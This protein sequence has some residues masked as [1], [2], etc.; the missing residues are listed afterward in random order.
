MSGG[1]SPFFSCSFL[2]P[3]STYLFYPLALRTLEELLLSPIGR[4]LRY[5][6]LLSSM[7]AVTP[8]P[9]KEHAELEEAQRCIEQVG[10]GTS[11]ATRKKMSILLVLLGC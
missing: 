7:I 11:G 9:S 2:L 6:A 5:K 4:I 8:F 1:R 3:P 10:E